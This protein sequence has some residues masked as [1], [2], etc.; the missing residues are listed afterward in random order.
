MAAKIDIAVISKR[1]P[2]IDDLAVEVVDYSSATFKMEIRQKPGDSGSP[3]VTLGNAAAGSEGISCTY[4]T[5]YV[6]PETGETFPA[7]VIVFQVNETTMESLALGNPTDGAVDCAYDLH[8]TPSG[9]AKFVL[10]YGAFTYSPGV[11]L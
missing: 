1:V 2:W 9:G 10:C 5:A 11:T 3:L 4:D 7:S 6:D 8:V